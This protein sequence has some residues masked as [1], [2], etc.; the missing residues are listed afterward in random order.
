MRKKL[1]F[2]FL[3]LLLFSKG[4]SQPEDSLLT[5]DSDS[6]NA[7]VKRDTAEA[8]CVVHIGRFLKSDGFRDELV[9]RFSLLNEITSEDIDNCIGESVGDILKMR[10]LIDVVKVGS[11]GQPEI[12]SLGGNTRGVNIFIDG[13][14]FQQQDLYF[15]HRGNI[16]LNSIFLSNVSKVEFLPAGLANLWGKGVGILGINIITKN[17]DGIK[18][19]SRVT[20]NRGPYGFR[21]TQVELGR[22][23]TS[24]GKFYLTTEFKKSNGY[25]TNADY[26]GFCLW[27][28]TTFNLNRR[29]DLKLSAYQY[30][31]KM[32]LPLFLD[33]SFQDTRKKVN[34]W[35][36]SGSLLLEEKENSILNLDFC[37][38]KQNQEVKSRSHNF[39]SK[40]IEEMFGLTATQTLK[41]KEKHYIKIEG[42][43]ERR[44]LETLMARRAGYGGYLSIADVIRIYPKLK[45][46]LFSRLEKEEEL[47]AGLSVCG[48]MS[49]QILNDVNLFSTLGRFV[50]YPTLMDRYWLP[51]SVSFKDTMA[52]YME[53]GS[54][55]LRLQKYFT[56]DLGA[57]VQKKNYKI[58]GYVFNCDIDDFIFWS[59]VDTSIYYGHF[60]PVNTEAKIWGAN[61][62]LGFE[63]FDHI[64]SHISYSFKQGKDSNRDTRL[65]YSPDHS[66]FGYI[67]FEDEFLK[68]EIGLK[69]RL[70]TNILSDR[71]MDEYEQD[72][73]PG[74]AILNGKITIRFLDFHFYYMVRNIT[75][76]VYRLIS[77]YHMPERSFWW[78]F[79]WE[80][81]D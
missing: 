27:G 70:E 38:D 5:A 58:S 64:R 81:F 26:D 73:E 22:A 54:G 42:C 28:K 16:D 24:R 12:G 23:L 36:V 68:R 8:V 47:K 35:G 14:T 66:L 1:S 39:E 50:G 65:P 80:F 75:G 52:D 78:G 20:A 10:S 67:Q 4:F 57:N 76:Q 49:Y 53:E 37:Y 34:N 13:H 61:I 43:G 19:Y 40:K 15:P 29:M 41:L 6:L 60:E 30:K 9:R 59:N 48:G 31:T 74:V 44:R 62:N 21:R 72:K 7:V 25:L 71:F 46:L 3:F 69:L 45:L 17:F 18:P 56:V 2:I 55:S 51:F 33:A 77:D 32:G 79:Y 11:W 63:F